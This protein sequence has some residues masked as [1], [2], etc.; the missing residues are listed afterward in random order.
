[1]Q[2]PFSKSALFMDNYNMSRLFL[3]IAAQR[4]TAR[5]KRLFA[6]FSYFF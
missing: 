1:M 5:H 2:A 6:F 3:Q 4:A